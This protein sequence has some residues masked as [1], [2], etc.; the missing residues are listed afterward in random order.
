[1]KDEWVLPYVQ[2]IGDKF[3]ASGFNSC[4][5]MP[6]VALGFAFPNEPKDEHT[7]T[8]FVITCV[9]YTG[10]NGMVM[11]NEAYSAYPNEDEV[12]MKEGCH[13]WVLAVDTGVKIVN[14]STSDM[15]LYNGKTMN[16]VHLYH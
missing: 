6:K 11:K 16:V 1:M 15:A 10:I 3:A 5:K 4:S 7:P 8:L 12:L 9:N 13:F 14:N 2:K